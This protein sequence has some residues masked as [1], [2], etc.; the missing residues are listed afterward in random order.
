[1]LKA[2]SLV[3]L[4]FLLLQF[5]IFGYRG[6]I[7]EPVVLAFIL[8]VILLVFQIKIFSN[9]KL[10]KI[11]QKKEKFLNGFLFLFLIFVCFQIKT[12]NSIEKLGTLA[13]LQDIQ[14]IGLIFKIGGTIIPVMAFTFFFSNISL[15]KKALILLISFAV[16]AYTA[17]TILSKQPLI[18]YFVFLLFLVSQ[19][20]ISRKYFILLLL[21]LI[22]P[23]IFVY[24]LRGSSEDFQEIIVMIIF[25][26]TMLA[27]SSHII[28]WLQDNKA[29]GYYPITEY[30]AIITKN[31][32]GFNPKSIGIAPSF[33][34]FFI[35]ILG[36]LGVLL[37]FLFIKYVSVFIKLIKTSSIEGRMLYF[38]W[39]VEL[40]SFF[41]DGIPHF[42]L[43]TSNGKLFWVLFLLTVLKITATQKGHKLLYYNE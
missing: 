28:T 25:R 7:S 16:S 24:F 33:L 38:F 31:V 37:P 18:P 1:M 9:E 12:L 2:L 39:V 19:K 32:F 21:L 8:L 23:V 41:T 5:S 4:L 13:S 36:P 3:Q 20:Y 26:V 11:S 14:H 43:S 29:L 35:V 10:V 27:E 22:P 30:T 40:L 17:L 6:L 42:Y 15:K 34:G